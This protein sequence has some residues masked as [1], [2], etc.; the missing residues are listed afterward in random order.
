MALFDNSLLLALGTPVQYRR[1]IVGTSR[2]SFS[3]L[4]VGGIWKELVRPVHD[5]HALLKAQTLAQS[6]I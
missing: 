1:N 4:L 5:W 6:L 2:M 3:S